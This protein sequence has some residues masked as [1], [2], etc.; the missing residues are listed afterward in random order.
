MDASVCV[1][2][3]GD[4]CLSPSSRFASGAVGEDVEGLSECKTSCR[5]LASV[6]VFGAAVTAFRL[7]FLAAFRAALAAACGVSLVTAPLSRLHNSSLCNNVEPQT[8]V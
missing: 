3:A 8:S 1:T 6:A 2:P 4:S 5:L 7:A